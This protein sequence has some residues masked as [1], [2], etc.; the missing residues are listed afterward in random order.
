MPTKVFQKMSNSRTDTD[1]SGSAAAVDATQAVERFCN[2]H[3]CAQAVLSV[4]AE[5]YGLDQAT[6][7]R[8]A[9][10]LGGG[11]GRMGGTCGTLTGAALVIGLELGPARAED[12]QAKERTYVATRLLQERFIDRHGGNQCRDLL[13][14]DL[15]K[16]EEYRQAREA[17][18]FKS[19]C[20][21]F[22]DTAVSVLDDIIKTAKQES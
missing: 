1:N 13:E 8:I 5:R 6:A 18:L 20:P 2:G 22:V 3:N 21:G 19:R 12:R 10:G 9:T 16:D 11:V 7:M 15:S 17:G 4:Y 14:K